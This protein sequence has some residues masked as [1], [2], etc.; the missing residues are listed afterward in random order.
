M[1]I[2]PRS[3]ADHLLDI[4]GDLDN[5]A[6]PTDGQLMNALSDLDAIS[7]RLGRLMLASSKP[8]RLNDA[9]RALHSMSINFARWTPSEADA[10]DCVRVACQCLAASNLTYRNIVAARRQRQKT[11]GNPHD[12]T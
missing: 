10:L 4:A 9:A 6:E 12:E 2:A 7:L 1:S 5:L 3:I 8:V 11:E